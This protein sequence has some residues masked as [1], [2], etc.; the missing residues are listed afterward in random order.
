MG[1]LRTLALS[2]A[3]TLPLFAQ[4]TSANDATT[5]VERRY[6]TQYGPF[7][8]RFDPDKA[9]GVFAILTNNDLGSIVGALDG[10]RLE[11]EWIEVDSRG[12]IR[13]A[14]SDDWSRFDAEYNVA[15]APDRWYGDWT[16]RLPE[17]GDVDSFIDEGTTFRCR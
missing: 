14:F 1:I 6:C 8:I 12:A 16:G 10:H 13:I 9:A 2:A 15:G 3:M 4:P 11:G 7:F 17:N 5:S